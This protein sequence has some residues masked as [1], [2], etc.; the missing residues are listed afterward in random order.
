MQQEFIDFLK[1]E[2]GQDF[3]DFKDWKLGM[4]LDLVESFIKSKNKLFPTDKEVELRAIQETTFPVVC[5][6]NTILEAQCQKKYI[7]GAKWMRDEFNK[8]KKV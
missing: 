7:E 1:E 4:C 5:Y 2:T 6:P 3:E 8:S